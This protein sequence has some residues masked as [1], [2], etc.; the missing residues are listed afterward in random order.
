VINDGTITFRQRSNHSNA[1]SVSLAPTSELVNNGKLVFQDGAD[2][3]GAGGTITNNPGASITKGGAT[4]TT[5]I[6]SAVD[7]HGLLRSESGLLKLT[8]AFPAITGSP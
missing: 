2:A 4:G 5:F 8:G 3:H 7:N 1:V 6:E